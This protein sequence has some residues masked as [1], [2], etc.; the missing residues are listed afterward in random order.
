MPI[1]L[2]CFVRAAR[3]ACLAALLA[4]SASGAAAEGETGSQASFSASDIAAVATG[5]FDR[6]GSRDAAMIVLPADESAEGADL[7]ILMEGKSDD[8]PPGWLGVVLQAPG[9]IAAW[10]SPLAGQVPTLTALEDGS[11]R[12]GTQNTGIGRNAWEEEVTLTAEDGRFL[13]SRFAYRSFDR[14]QDEAPIECDLDLFA[15]TGV[16]NDRTIDF[17]PRRV[18]YLDFDA[19]DARGICGAD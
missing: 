17:E 13:V 2:P 7:Y 6:D 9:R 18:A 15:G 4:I 5:D 1:A 10:S 3:P 14:L 19:A 12:V 11:L 8:L 16:L